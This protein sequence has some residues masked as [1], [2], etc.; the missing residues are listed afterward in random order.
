MDPSAIRQ[1]LTDMGFQQDKAKRGLVTWIYAT[2]AVALFIAVAFI[3]W[4]VKDR[5]ES[6]RRHSQEKEA[7]HKEYFKMITKILEKADKIE[8][9]ADT[10]SK[11][12]N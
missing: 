9:K 3:M 1:E 11:P 5:N 4:L 12:I 6:E 7:I 8:Q 10:L 2:L